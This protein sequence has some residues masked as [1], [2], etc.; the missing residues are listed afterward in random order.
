VPSPQIAT[1]VQN[2]PETG[3]TRR[4]APVALLVVGG[5]D[6]G[7]GAGLFRD[8]ATARALG[9]RVH[10]VGT[11]WTE[12]TEG[13]HR[14]EPRD[15]GALS[16]GLAEALADLRPAAVK[17]GMAVSPVHADALL[18]ALATYAGPIVVDPVLA[19]SRGGPLWQAPAGAL[20]PLLRRAALVTPNALEAAA[21][22]GQR[23]E[24]VAAATSAAEALLGEGLA[25]VLVKGGHLADSGLVT[26]VLA[27]AGGVQRFSHPRIAG[28]SPRGTGCAL[29]TALAVALG[30]GQPL[31]T[32]VETA[33]T[34][35]A[36]AIAGAQA[37]GAE[38]HLD[39]SA[40]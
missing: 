4:E 22:T 30:Q 31:A 14:V 29:A 24:S 5:L 1:S 16:R 3:P 25:A 15:P 7:G 18:A 21:L 6:P 8:V 32:A 9:A 19:T 37:V 27:T 17:V 39:R 35:L 26:D 2:G 12:Q 34:W 28:P 20:L 13:I 10:A 23:I 40:G 38:R 33:T 11:A 36:A